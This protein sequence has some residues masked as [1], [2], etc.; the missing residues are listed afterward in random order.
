[1]QAVIVVQRRQNQWLRD[2]PV[3][4]NGITGLAVVKADGKVLR[5]AAD[6]T[7]NEVVVHGSENSRAITG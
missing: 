6:K 5:F 3:L 2:K 1:L 7:V 4:D